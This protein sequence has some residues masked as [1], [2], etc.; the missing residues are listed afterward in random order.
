MLNEDIGD[1]E[2]DLSAER[3]IRHRATPLDSLLGKRIR[4]LRRRRGITQTVLASHIGV[5]FQQ[6]QKY[7]RGANRIS[8]VTLVRM[9][10]LLGV[11]PE[12]LVADL[13][14][15]DR[16]PDDVRL[17]DLFTGMRDPAWRR[18]VLELVETLSIASRR[19]R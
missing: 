8:V 18:L 10:E 12:R 19:G 16:S 9:A 3:V 6:V 11:P 5:T 17:L 14:S 4:E 13:S 15:T 2:L 1:T 7:E